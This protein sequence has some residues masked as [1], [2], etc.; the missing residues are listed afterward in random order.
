MQTTDETAITEI[1]IEPDGRIFVFGMSREV[2][3]LLA[4]ICPTAAQLCADLP[5]KPDRRPAGSSAE[6]SASAPL[7]VTGERSND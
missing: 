6:R 3:E 5:S 2:L 7:H 1:T 4:T